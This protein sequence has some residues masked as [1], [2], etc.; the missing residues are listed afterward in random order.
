MTKQNQEPTPTKIMY[1]ITHLKGDPMS[2]RKQA[3]A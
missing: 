2:H 3:N 1:I